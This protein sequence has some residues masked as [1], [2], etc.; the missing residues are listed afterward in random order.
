MFAFVLVHKKYAD[1]QIY[2]AGAC[3]CSNI[4]SGTKDI[5]VESQLMN[6]ILGTHIYGVES[7][8]AGSHITTQFPL[9]ALLRP[10]RGP[11]SSSSACASA[12][13]LNL[14]LLLLAPAPPAPASSPALM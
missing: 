5:A 3:G 12:A 9:L 13:S 14:L 10:A 11:P 1:P 2:A 8:P 4:L 6:I 7:A